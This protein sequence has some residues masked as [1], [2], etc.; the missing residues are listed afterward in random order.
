MT[1]QKKKV[2]LKAILTYPVWLP[3]Q[4]EALHRRNVEEWMKLHGLKEWPKVEVNITKNIFGAKLK[5]KKTGE[6][7]EL[8]KNQYEIIEDRGE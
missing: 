4:S 3:W 7:I 6:V 8:D 5:N 2:G 1:E